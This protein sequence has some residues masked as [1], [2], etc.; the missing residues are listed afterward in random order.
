MAQRISLGRIVLYTLSEVDVARINNNRRADHT[1]GNTADIGQE[2]PMIVTRV[3]KHGL[4]N[5]QVHLDGTDLY[6]VE[7]IGE[8][9]APESPFVGTWRWPPFVPG[10]G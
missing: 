2:F 10:H 1:C 5:G 7:G 8:N 3:Q 4:I 6:W 9:V